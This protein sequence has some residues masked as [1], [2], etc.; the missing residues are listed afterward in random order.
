MEDPLVVGLQATSP[1]ERNVRN[2]MSDCCPV[3]AEVGS[4]SGSEEYRPI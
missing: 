1:K 4:V 2:S 3:L